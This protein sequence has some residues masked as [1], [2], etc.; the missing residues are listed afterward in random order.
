MVLTILLIVVAVVA[1]VMIYS[2]KAKNTD[3][4]GPMNNN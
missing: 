4:N 2:A 3:S 1:I